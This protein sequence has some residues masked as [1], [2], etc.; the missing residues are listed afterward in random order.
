M[1]IED[2]F[3][4]L[5]HKC[6]VSGE[7]LVSGMEQEPNVFYAETKSEFDKSKL[8]VIIKGPKQ[9]RIRTESVLLKYNCCQYTYWPRKNGVYTIYITWE[10]KPVL[11]SPFSIAIY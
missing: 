4:N 2:L 6:S 7:G 9:K 11:G 8:E 1:K 3:E 10:G 5:D